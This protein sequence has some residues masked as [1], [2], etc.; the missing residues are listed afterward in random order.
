MIDQTVLKQL[1]G[2][3]SKYFKCETMEPKLR[4]TAVEKG[5]SI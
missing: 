3:W 4:Y 5:T 2:L 1:K